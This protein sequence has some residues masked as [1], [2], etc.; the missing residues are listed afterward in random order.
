MGV[1]ALAREALAVDIGIPEPGGATR[2]ALIER[3]RLHFYRTL[4][5]ISA[6]D[7]SDIPL[8]ELAVSIDRMAAE[9]KA[10]ELWPKLCIYMGL[11]VAEKRGAMALSLD[12]SFP[13][14]EPEGSSRIFDVVH[15]LIVSG[16]TSSKTYPLLL[17]E[18]GDK[19]QEVVV[20]L[21]LFSAY[22][23]SNLPAAIA[24]ATPEARTH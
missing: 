11:R 22:G 9:E 1:P 3:E 2:G 21:L 20:A 6:P 5:E 13:L 8:P 4:S 12:G 19:A 17:Q 10:A 23:Q 14:S 18:R 16:G 7:F 24:A 15:R